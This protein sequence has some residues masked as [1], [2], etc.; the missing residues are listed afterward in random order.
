MDENNKSEF[1]EKNELLEIKFRE[2]TS[3][4]NFKNPIVENTTSRNR[5]ALNYEK[6]KE[7]TLN[8]K[9]I[10]LIND[11]MKRE[12]DIINKEIEMQEKNISIVKEN[13]NKI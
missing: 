6:E 10:K 13:L 4:T 3:T 5:S 12:I 2:N 9:D 1:M 11:T 7:I 8:K